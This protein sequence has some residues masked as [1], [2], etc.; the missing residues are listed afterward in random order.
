MEDECERKWDDIVKMYATATEDCDRIWKE[1][2]KKN[3]V[4]TSTCSSTLPAP[5]L[6]KDSP[7]YREL[8]PISSRDQEEVHEENA[9]GTSSTRL[10]IRH[11]TLSWLCPR[12]LRSVGHLN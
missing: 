8:E 1:K 5:M 4:V 12:C 7:R 10:S 11:F 3:L 9:G 2:E 6:R